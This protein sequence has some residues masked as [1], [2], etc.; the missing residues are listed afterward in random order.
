MA[1]VKISALPAATSVASADV[2]PIVQ[3]ATT[4]KATFGDVAGAVGG[5]R[6]FASTA[7]RDA[8]ITS[9]A[10]GMVV[11]VNSNDASE[12]LYHYSGGAWYKG[13]TWNQPWGSVGYV[14]L[15]SLSQTGISTVTDVTGASITFTAISNRLYKVSAHGY[16]N[17]TDTGVTTNLMLRNSSNTTLQQATSW[18][19]SSNIG[20]F[21]TL[22]YVS[23]LSAGSVTLKMSVQK[24][25]GTGTITVEG[26]AS[27]PFTFI[28]EDIGPSGAPA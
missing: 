22:V 4:K 9:P 5:I 11:Y 26:G 3:S 12:G 21:N 17:S 1:N 18:S 13:A 7:A 2:L 27:Y 25:S 28:I 24:Q 10:A 16:T 19:G 6:V 20:V 15:T 14:S 8:A 23:T